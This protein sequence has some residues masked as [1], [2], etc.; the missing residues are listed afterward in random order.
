MTFTG[1]QTGYGL[2]RR[3][4]VSFA[5]P[6]RPPAI[7]VANHRISSTLV[8]RYVGVKWTTIIPDSHPCCVVYD[9]FRL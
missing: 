9:A 7:Y 2:S 5:E 6:S 3:F 4:A 8:A 1:C